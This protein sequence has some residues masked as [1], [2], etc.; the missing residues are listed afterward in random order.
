MKLRKYLLFKVHVDHIQCD[1]VIATMVIRLLDDP[2]RCARSVVADLC[3]LGLGYMGPGMVY[4]V[5]S[6]PIGS[7]LLLNDTCGP[8][9]TIFELYA[10]PEAI[11]SWNCKN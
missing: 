6:P 3:H 9:L 4:S 7:N 11:A 2:T 5:G 1:K 10:A 8:S